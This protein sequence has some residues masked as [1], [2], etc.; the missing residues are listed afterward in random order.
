[1]P[2]QY[3]RFDM[4]ENAW[5]FPGCTWLTGVLWLLPA[6]MIL[7]SPIPTMA[8]DKHLEQLAEAQE[9]VDAGDAEEAIKLLNK[10]VKAKPPLAEAFLLRST[11]NFMVGDLKTG[12]SDLEMALEIDSTMRQAWL[13]RAGLDLSEGK[14]DA[15]LEALTKAKDLDP[16]AIDNDL[17]LGVVLVLKGDIEPA[18]QHFAA[19]IQ[20]SGGSAEAYFVVARNY[21]MAGLAGP[22]IEHLKQAIQLDERVRLQARTDP[23]FQDLE[24]NRRFQDLLLTDTFQPETGSHF[25]VQKFDS[26][27]GGLDS[28]LVS[29]TL[30]A[31][32]FSGQPFDPRVEVTPDWALIWSE[33]RIKIMSSDGGGGQVQLTAP[34]NSFTPS[35]WKRRSEE[36][37]REITVRLLSRQR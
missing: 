1:V 34:P 32:Q 17:N 36:L 30:D 10:A 8:T 23:N 33:Y 4:Q 7:L 5:S 15:A 2:V 28:P 14:Y 20:R 24:S 13:N 31:L 21:A 29:A 27:F 16:A 12:R 19:H 25:A 26:P 11:A 22:A 3:I 18:S 6:L 37:F 9:F 35:E